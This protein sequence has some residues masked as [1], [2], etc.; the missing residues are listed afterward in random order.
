MTRYCNCCRR[1]VDIDGVNVKHSEPVCTRWKALQQSTGQV[2]PTT[3]LCSTR[4][5][6]FEPESTLDRTGR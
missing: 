2:H 3:A 4:E 1:S 6:E 5:E